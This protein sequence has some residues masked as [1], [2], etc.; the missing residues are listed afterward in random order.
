MPR[1]PRLYLPGA[2]YHITLRGNHRQDIFFTPAD[3]QTFTDIVAEVVPRFGAR[4]HAYCSDR[5]SY[6]SFFV[7]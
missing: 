5:K 6:V 4:L 2:F 3:Q 1:R 7:T